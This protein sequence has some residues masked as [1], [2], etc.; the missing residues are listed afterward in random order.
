MKRP[1]DLSGQE[2]AKL[3][4]RY[5]YQVT[6]QTGSHMRL[7]SDIKGTE[8]RITIPAHGELRVGTLSAILTSVAAYLE[9]DF[10]D[11]LNELF[12]V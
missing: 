11:F 9:K 10:Q 12:Q 7:T 5:G 8:H 1:R 3:L 2:L 6:R 4:R